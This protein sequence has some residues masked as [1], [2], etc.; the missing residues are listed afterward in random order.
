VFFPAP[1]SKLISVAERFPRDA[2]QNGVLDLPGFLDSPI[3]DWIVDRLCRTSITPNQV[4]FVTMLIGIAVTALFATGHLW[5]GVGLAYAIE[6]LD[7]V[8]GKLA[9]T[10]VETTTTGEWE[11]VVDYCVELS[12][13][14]TLAYHFHGQ[15]LHSAYRLLVLLVGSDLVDRLAKRMVKK[16]VGRNLDDVSSFDRFV[17]WI[18]S[19][20]NINIWVLIAALAFGHAMDGFVLFC[21]WGAVTT[22]AHVVR[23]IQIQ[24]ERDPVGLSGT[25]R[26]VD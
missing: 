19:R 18:G 26:L 8:D 13:W 22:A 24:L 4:T 14:T 23:A 1:S 12:W 3:E 17:R 25:D 2:A 9:R 21:C 16:K 7:G 5:W 6:L 15:G 11:H 20:R 10:K